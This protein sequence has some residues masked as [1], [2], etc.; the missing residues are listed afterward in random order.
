MT[1]VQLQF[2][3]SRPM[4]DQLLAQIARVHSVYGMTRVQPTP[5]LDGLM[6]DYDATRLTPLDVEAVLRR[7]GI[8]AK[9]VG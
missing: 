3:L 5:S 2:S 7:A 8:P 4:D 1:K 6:V 9:L